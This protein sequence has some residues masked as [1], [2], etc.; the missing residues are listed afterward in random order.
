ML[1]KVL[2]SLLCCAVCFSS[3]QCDASYS[4]DTYVN[5][6]QSISEPDPN[7]ADL[8]GYSYSQ[9]PNNNYLPPSTPPPVYGAPQALDYNPPSPS[10]G[11]PQPNYGPP[12]PNYGAP[13][14]PSNY[15]PPQ[16]NYGPPQPNYGPPPPVYYK[17]LPFPSDP[18]DHYALL[19][20]LKTKLN[21][22]TIGKILLKLLIFKKIIKFIGL[23]CLLLF[24]PKLK[25]MFKEDTSTEEDTMESKQVETERDLL[26]RRIEEVHRFAMRSLK[27]FQDDLV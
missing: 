1:E 19:A 12:H 6:L 18:R 22:F 8:G 24:L 25:D 20:K 26:K 14:P 16:A 9:P 11:P 10:Y 15:G 21:L 5:A 4:Q 27:K 23:I 2:I 7:G 13:P 3:V 17:P